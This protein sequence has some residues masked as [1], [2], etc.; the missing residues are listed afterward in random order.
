MIAYELHISAF[1]ANQI[2]TQD[3]NMRTAFAKLAPKYLE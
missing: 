3:C 1:T 2:R